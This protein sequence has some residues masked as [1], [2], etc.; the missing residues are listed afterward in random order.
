MSRPRHPA[1]VFGHPVSDDSPQ[2]RHDRERHWCPFVD[3]PCDKKTRLLP[4]PMGVCSVQW[5][6][7]VIA[8]SPRRFLQDNTVFRDIARHYF[9][10][11]EN[12]LLF[13]EISVP[14][15]AHIGRFDYVLARHK[16]LSSQI[17]DFVVIELQT[18]QTTDTGK[19]IDG[20]RDFMEGRAIAGATYGFGLN[21]ADIWKRAFTQ[22]LTKGT[23][24]ERWGHK[25]YWVAQDQVYQD[26]LNRYNLH[27]MSYDP[28]HNTVF[29]VYDLKRA[30]DRYEIVRTRA[31]SSTVAQLFHAFRTNL[32]IPPK[33]EFLSKLTAKAQR[34]IGIDLQ[35]KLQLA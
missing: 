26:L 6:D 18:G 5:D 1:E 16:P 19:L 35:L 32:D 10:A 24:L 8:L 2:A 28:A 3:K 21:F 31:Q 9:G 30:G 34:S 20:L 22:V 14:H 11:T 4:Y 25:I 7:Q 27:G 17:E 29:F 15:A 12:L 33:D 23:I 13:D